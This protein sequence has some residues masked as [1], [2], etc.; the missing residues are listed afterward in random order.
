MSDLD[1]IPNPGISTHPFF[2][3]REV[4]VNSRGNELNAILGFPSDPRGLIIFAHGSGSGRYSERNIFVAR[5]LER[6]HFATLLIDLLNEHE[7]EDRRNAFDIPLLAERLSGAKEWATSQPGLEHLNI[8]YFGGSTGAGAALFAVA[9]DPVKVDAVVSRGGR[10]D[11]AED[12]LKWVS[13]PTL[14]IVGG[15]D[16]VVIDLNKKA[17]SA[18][19]CRKDMRIVPGATHLFE[20]PGTLEFVAKLA[21]DWFSANIKARAVK[22]LRRAN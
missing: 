2:R 22:D 17:M 20:E 5:A 19:T 3:E 7:A 13:V 6:N 12:A 9:H 15:K 8:G 11:L 1:P 4:V 18:L 14:L 10:P 16:N 21:T